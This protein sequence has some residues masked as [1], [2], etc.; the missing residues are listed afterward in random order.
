MKLD[1]RLLASIV[2]FSGSALAASASQ[3]IDVKDELVD[4][5]TPGSIY[6]STDS[7]FD[8]HD[9]VCRAIAASRVRGTKLSASHPQVQ[10]LER[11]RKDL[12][13]R[14]AQ[15]PEGLVVL[16]HADEKASAI[17]CAPGIEKQVTRVT[18]VD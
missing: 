8:E 18:S 3:S 7:L 2:F 6:V 15:E 9:R 13:V 5:G 1:K 14:G 4:E 10:I 11:M 16:R 12:Q 17:G